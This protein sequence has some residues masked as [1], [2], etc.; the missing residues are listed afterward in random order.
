[1]RAHSA[2]RAAAARSSSARINKRSGISAAITRIANVTA[3][4]QAASRGGSASPAAYRA[5]LKHLSAR[6]LARTIIAATSHR[7]GAQQH[8]A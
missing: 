7:C 4:K 1:M 6:A 8:R 5:R 3:S 2:A